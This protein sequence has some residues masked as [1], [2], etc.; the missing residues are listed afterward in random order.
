LTSNR[1]GSRL[2]QHQQTQRIKRRL[3]ALFAASSAKPREE[4][5][6]SVL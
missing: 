6:F 2:R 5:L 3:I 4:K 1:S